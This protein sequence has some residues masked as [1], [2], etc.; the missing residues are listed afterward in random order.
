MLHIARDD[1]Q[2]FEDLS[3]YSSSKEYNKRRKNR[4]GHTV[5]KCILGVFCA[6]LIV[7]GSGLIYIAT[8]LLDD[9]TTTNITKDPTALGIDPA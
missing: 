7:F 3:S 5:L 9:L 8:H 4:R 1:A 6:L 2:E